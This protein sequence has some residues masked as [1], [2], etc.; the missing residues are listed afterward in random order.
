MLII[1]H[2]YLVNQIYI[3]FLA[4]ITYVNYIC[5]AQIFKDQDM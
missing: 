4:V 3:A 5:M 2:S 1:I